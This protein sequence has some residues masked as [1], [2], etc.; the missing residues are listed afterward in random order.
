MCS[1]CELCFVAGVGERSL[2][3][4]IFW[5]QGKK[6]TIGL[7]LHQLLQYIFSV[8]A[9]SAQVRVQQVGGI[10]NWWLA[11]AGQRLERKTTFCLWLWHVHPCSISNSTKCYC[12]F[13]AVVHQITTS[14]GPLFA[15]QCRT[16]RKKHLSFNFQTEISVKW[17]FVEV[18]HDDVQK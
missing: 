3:L 9:R 17:S 8:R 7:L 4:D 1:V 18:G 13:K 12:N 15:F 16:V 6:Q 10:H 14:F 5:V 11:H 2:I